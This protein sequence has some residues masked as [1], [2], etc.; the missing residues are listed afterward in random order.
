MPEHWR[1]VWAI[2]GDGTVNEVLQKLQGT[3]V[4]LAIFPAGTGNVIAKEWGI[5]RRFSSAYEV[6]TDGERHPCDVGLCNGRA[7]LFMASAGFDAD[8]VHVVSQRRRGAMKMRDYIPAVRQVMA[9]AESRFR[10]HL[11]G[12][13]LGGFSWLAVLNT[14]RYGSG[15]P[16]CPAARMDDGKLDVVGLRDPIG[17]RMYRVLWRALRGRLTEFADC[18]VA[19]AQ[20]VVIEGASKTQVDGDPHGPGDLEIQVQPAAIQLLVPRS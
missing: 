13:P 14:R 20:H 19:Q 10:V 11:D 15:F 17:P 4:P 3:P 6:A 9:A 7:F 5:A 2:G 1:S 16:L 8:V 18:L 12:E